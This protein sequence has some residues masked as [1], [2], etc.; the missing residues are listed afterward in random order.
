MANSGSAF[1]RGLH[2]RY[3]S[4]KVRWPTYVRMP[5][6][7]LSS[8][9]HRSNFKINNLDIFAVRIFSSDVETFEPDRSRSEGENYKMIIST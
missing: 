9:G 7:T 1:M 6:A 8:F 3:S 2:D 4:F 5:M